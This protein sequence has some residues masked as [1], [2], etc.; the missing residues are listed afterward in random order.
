MGTANK[1]GMRFP[2]QTGHFYEFVITL[3]GQTTLEDMDGITLS[4]VGFFYV[5][6]LY[7]VFLSFKDAFSFFW[8]FDKITLS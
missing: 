8:S 6:L 7:S 5:C 3:E 2:L 1:F 4:C